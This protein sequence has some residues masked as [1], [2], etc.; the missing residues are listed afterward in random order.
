MIF[1]NLI[2]FI[3]FY[4]SVYTETTLAKIDSCFL[5]TKQIK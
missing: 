5:S 2:Y 4:S 3:G 1:S